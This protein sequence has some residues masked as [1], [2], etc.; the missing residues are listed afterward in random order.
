ML[1]DESNQKKLETEVWQCLDS[2]HHLLK[3]REILHQ[4]LRQGWMELTSARYGMGPSRISSLLFS[5]K[6]HA[7]SSVVDI[8]VS[9]SDSTGRDSGV[10]LDNQPHGAALAFD[11]I[12]DKAGN[13]ERPSVTNTGDST[14]SDKR[15][16]SSNPRRSTTV[17]TGWYLVYLEPFAYASCWSVGPLS[18]TDGEEKEVDEIE[19]LIDDYS[20]DS[21]DES[22]PA[23]TPKEKAQPLYWFGTLVSPHLRSAQD[24]F[25]QA[26]EL[27]VEIVNA[28]TEVTHAHSNVLKLRE[29]MTSEEN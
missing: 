2:V 5:L 24:S 21:P 12:R 1:E 3:R 11:L 25:S 23:E 7:P 6:P 27:I 14:E 17:S 15:E 16:P 22:S 18:R 20:A 13:D 19:R 10:K 28:Q 9:P 26:L 4:T 8:R 29:A